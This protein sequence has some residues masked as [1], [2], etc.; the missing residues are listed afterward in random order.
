MLSSFKLYIL[1][2]FILILFDKFLE[3]WINIASLPIS[4][5]IDS[6][7]TRYFYLDILYEP[8]KYE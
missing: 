2:K 7:K 3:N 1:A 5:N 4:K 8:R 6:I